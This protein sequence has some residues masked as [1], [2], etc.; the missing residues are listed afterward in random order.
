LRPGAGRQ[1]LRAAS[2][3]NIARIYEASGD[4]PSALRNYEWAQAERP[5]YQEAIDRMKGKL[6]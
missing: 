1:F 4:F 3:Y 2:Y 6:K 5:A